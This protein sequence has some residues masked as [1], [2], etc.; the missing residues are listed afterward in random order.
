M[1]ELFGIPTGT[2]AVV[3]GAVLALAAIVLGFLALRNR[4][5][6]R[7]G[8]RSAAR[9]PART[10]LI[11][12]GLMLG[13]TIVASALATGDTMSYTI[14]SEALTAMGQVDEIVSARGTNVDVD[15]D[16]G[17]ATGARYL[18]ATTAAEVV[19]AARA[20]GL[21]D[22]VAP[23]IG[24]QVSVRAPRSGQIEP[25]VTL[26][27][28]AADDARAFGIPL[29]R[30]ERGEV[31]LNSQ[32]AEEL[33]VAAGG[34]V[35][36]MAG[37][38]DVALRVAEIV[39]VDG[40]GT[41][42]AAVMA[43]LPDAQAL[44]GLERSVRH[45]IVS[46]VGDHVEG[47]KRTDEVV[48]ALAPT[49]DALKLEAEPVKR[50]ALDEAD[51]GGAAFMSLF[52]TFG[53]FSIFAGLL[54]IFL[55]FVMLAAERR[56]ELG[57]ARAV[58]TQRRHLIQMYLF[59]G[60]A[61]DVVAALVGAALGALVAYGMVAGMGAAFDAFGVDVRYHVTLRSLVIAYALGM[62]ITLAVVTFSAWRV[63]VLTISS[64]IR[65]LPDPPGRR[66]KRHWILGGLA[67]LAGLALIASGISAADALTIGLGFSL[68]VMG[69]VPISRALGLPERAAFTS[70]GLLLVAYWLLPFEVME[71]VT[72][73]ELAM[74]FSIWVAGG[75]L[76]VT[77]AIWT[78]VYNADLVLGAVHAVFGRIRALA[79][80]LRLAL[81][82]PLRSRFRTG[83]TLAM[84]T[85]V[86]FTLVAGVTI[87][88]SFMKANDDPRRF[89]G[90]FDVRAEVA[91]TSE[92]GNVAAAVHRSGIGGITVTATQSLVGVRAAQV[93]SGRAHAD[94]P[95]RGLDYGFAQNTTYAMSAVANGYADDAAVWKAL[96]EEPDAAIVDQWVVPRRSQWG[97][98]PPPD[99]EI[100]GF[101]VE[102]ER[103]DAVPIDVYDP[104]TN[105]HLRL[106]VIGVLEDSAPPSMVG[107]S[108]SQRTLDGT[109]GP[110]ARPS[111]FYFR[112]APGVDSTATAQALE[113][114][115]ATEGMEAESI[116]DVLDE[117]MAAGWTFNRLVQ[118]F[119]GL[120]LVVGVAALGVISARAVVE[121]RQ[122][123]GVMRAIGFRRGMVQASFLLEAS[124]VA[125]TAIVLGTALGLVIGLNVVVDSRQQPS[126]EHLA[127]VIPWSNLIV[128]YAV[129]YAV[130]LA[131]TF[132]PALRASRVYPAEALR[133]Q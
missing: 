53:M 74:G 96:A 89:G 78:L 117:A 8:F 92:I 40:T 61:Y 20:S 130:A 33:Q 16:I 71:Q 24:E 133:Y 51:L 65:N 67:L 90:G 119:L 110:R 25:R 37:R 41:K 55:I 104:Q 23:A 15:A 52:M 2:L 94:Y 39:D 7:L 31:L 123:I 1:R 35:H 100:T 86:V 72:R 38:A 127:M 34:T 5:F 69:V 101:Y 105:R 13:T 131:A 32:A 112:L 4:V 120:G 77:G 128:V 18:D 44:L 91:P 54:L 126:Y 12:L 56:G 70:G 14:R 75:M 10:L 106:R 29:D 103:F 27:A 21:V 83:I 79:P 80:V 84:F 121:R 73:R 30:L 36:L 132:A 115:F 9:R 98:G 113:R 111:A 11:V 64:A 85:L 118:G 108:A 57:I 125:L 87:N 93:G 19:T 49:L 102:D 97:F 76:V 43:L 129:V 114:T 28:A 47:A 6:V 60:T 42:D 48:A 46:N 26:F 58:G 109:F 99:F 88:G 82:Y 116:A 50:D 17:Q 124:F 107:I 68:C 59:E 3:L 95:L 45:V 81:A 62:L 66:R 63:S 22:A 122:Q